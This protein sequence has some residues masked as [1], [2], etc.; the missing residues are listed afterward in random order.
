MKLWWIIKNG[1]YE[2][3]VMS[4]IVNSMKQDLTQIF[5]HSHSAA[6]LW[7]DLKER[8][9]SYSG[10]LVDQLE[11]DVLQISQCNSTV[12]DYFNK[13]KKIWDELQ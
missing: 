8:Y 3:T 9:S 10:S 6:R 2:T 1:L 5:I 11:R 4:W 12:T 7:E 13:L